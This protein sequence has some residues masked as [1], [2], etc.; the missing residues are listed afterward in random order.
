MGILRLAH[1]DLRVPDL[2]LATAYYTEVVGMQLVERDDDTVYL[3][4]WDEADHHSVRLRYANRNGLDQISFKVEAEDDLAVLEARVESY[5]YAV[6][7]I[8][9]GEEVGQGESIRFEAP[10]GQVVELVHDVEKVGRCWASS[11]RH[12][13]RWACRAS[14]RPAWTTR[15][16][17]PRR[18]ARPAGSTWTSS[19]SA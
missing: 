9:K 14:P 16:S 3:K 15:W 17:P 11:I 19:A 18:S 6:K 2:D 12:R 1:V 8:S 10:S 7:R 5:G 4:C 13:C